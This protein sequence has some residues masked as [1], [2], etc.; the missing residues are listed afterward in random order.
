MAGGESTFDQFVRNSKCPNTGVVGYRQLKK[1][2]GKV[3]LELGELEQAETF[4][5]ESYSELLKR[6]KDIP[7]NWADIRVNQAAGRL[8]HFY[9]ATGN[10]QQLLK[11]NELFDPEL[12]DWPTSN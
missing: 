12:P 3:L 8:V 10:R 1:P 6:K 4:L 11:W 5:L 2:L 7:A 9:Q